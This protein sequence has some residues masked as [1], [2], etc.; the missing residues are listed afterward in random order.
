MDF[1]EAHKALQ[2]LADGKYNALEYSV[3]TAS[4]GDMAQVCKVYVSDYSYY[5]GKTWEKALTKA[6]E[7]IHPTKPAKLE[8]PSIPELEVAA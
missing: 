7:A 4:N 2:E 3:E 5:S 1:K 8:V 6:Y